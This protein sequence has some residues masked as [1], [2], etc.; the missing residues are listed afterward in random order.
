M[1][2]RFYVS[3]ALSAGPLL[4][5]GPEAHHLV[6][7]R[8]LGEADVVT[9]FNGD[10]CEYPARILDIE[11]RRV[12]VE[13]GAGVKVNRELVFPLTIVAPLSK[14]DRGQ[15]M[16]EKLTELGVSR[17]VPL[18]TKRSIVKV[19]NKGEKLNRY[20]IEASKQCGRNVLMT[21]DDP[22]TLPTSSGGE[23][24]VKGWTDLYCRNSLQGQRYLADPGG[25]VKLG[26]VAA[27]DGAGLIFAVGPEGG[28][29][30]DE[31]A[32]AV[33]AGWQRVNLGPRILRI[34]TAAIVVASWAANSRL[35]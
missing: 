18:S 15:F 13:V 2:D 5:D 14:G 11:R 34:E 25:E 22:F 10:G 20:V 35:C 8:R 3:C 4:I 19:D 17:Y 29:T 1:P 28:F 32:D 31:V 6:H 33:A 21:V 9:L 24:G 26:E 16:I 30:A 12:M 23:G 7:V 27:G